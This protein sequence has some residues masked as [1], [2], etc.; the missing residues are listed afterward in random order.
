M[1]LDTLKK[2]HNALKNVHFTKLA[3]DIHWIKER[4]EAE[5]QEEFI[6]FPLKGD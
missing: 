2:R 3:R 4:L 5:D 6:R 1:Q